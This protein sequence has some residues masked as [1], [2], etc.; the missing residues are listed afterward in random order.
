VVPTAQRH[1]RAA[2]K[3]WHDNRP[4]APDLFRTELERAFD[5]ITMQP[6]IGPKVPGVTSEGIRRFHLS[7]IHYHVYYRVS[8]DLLEVL[9]VWHVS[10]ESAPRL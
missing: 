1:V 4:A 3:W 8:D 9:A 5:F 10:R 2:S 6:G 7:R